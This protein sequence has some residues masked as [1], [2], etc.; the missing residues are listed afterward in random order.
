MIGSAQLQLS[1]QGFKQF[2]MKRT[3]KDP[4]PIIDNSLWKAMKLVDIVRE[5]LCHLPYYEWV[6]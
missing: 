1:A 5:L 2:L 4:V 6:R 3:C